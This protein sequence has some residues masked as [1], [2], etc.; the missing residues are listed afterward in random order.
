MRKG[1]CALALCLLLTG[2]VER[3]AVETPILE[4]AAEVSEDAVLLTVDGREVP[5][6]RYLYWLAY[7]CDQIQNQYQEAGLEPDWQAPISGGE[8][9][10]YAKDQA[11][12]D[13]ALYAT[14]ENWAER[15]GCTLTQ[16]D[17]EA[18]E[19]EWRKKAESQGGEEAYLASLADQGLD[20]ARARE[21]AQVGMAYAK[22]RALCAQEG[23]PL[24]PQG[25]ALSAYAQKSGLL[26]VDRILVSAGED[27]EAA[28][29]RAAEL[30]SRLNGA[31]GDSAGFA[32]LALEGDDPAGPRMVSIGDGSLDPALE[33]A[34]L[35]LEAGQ[36]SGILE[37]GEG[38]S[39]LR[40]LEDDSDAL[41]DGYFDDALRSGAEGAAVETTAE[42]D[43]LEA[44]VFYG[45]LQK[46]R[47]A[48]E[49]SET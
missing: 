41:L 24:H 17:R 2:C 39:I 10:D 21:L 5:A 20:E 12:A 7:T 37:S 15:Y 18:L 13:A 28:R 45:R 3:E 34:A 33:E 4:R 49:K 14:V 48:E 46:L 1:Y 19:G 47:N 32:A 31:D 36:C 22:L 27:R 8:L 25:E 16:E 6:W 38:F 29:S 26:T 23:S 44:D 42:Y 30:F 11:L 40:R 9:R 43:A 35:A